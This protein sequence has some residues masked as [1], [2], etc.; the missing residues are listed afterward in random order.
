MINLL[1]SLWCFKVR[2]VTFHSGYDFGYLLK[3]V[4]GEEL[5]AGEEEFFDMLRV[6]RLY[7]LPVFG[8]LSGTL[9]RLCCAANRFTSQTFM[10]SSTSW[11]S[12]IICT[13]AWTKLRKLCKFN[14][15]DLNI[16]YDMCQGQWVHPCTICISNGIQFCD[17]IVEPMWW[18]SNKVLL[19]SES[20]CKIAEVKLPVYKKLSSP[21]LGEKRGPTFQLLLTTGSGNRYMYLFYFN[22]GLFSS[23][24]FALHLRIW[25][26]STCNIKVLNHVSKSMVGFG[27]IAWRGGITVH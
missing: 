17:R 24:K 5:P 20:Y 11:S 6:S 9:L 3:V 8:W 1:L 27:T 23:C 13:E 22:H 19:S 2:W 10:I 12:V 21:I 16:R 15:L 4:T 25:I 7:M 18:K 14:G 26:G